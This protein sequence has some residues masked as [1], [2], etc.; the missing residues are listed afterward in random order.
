MDIEILF[1]GKLTTYSHVTNLKEKEDY[2]EFD[3]IDI[4]KKFF[5][6]T[7]HEHIKTKGE[8]TKWVN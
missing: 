6:I 8:I 3:C 1:N 4:V 2:I 5:K 7:A